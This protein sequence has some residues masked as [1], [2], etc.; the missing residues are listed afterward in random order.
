MRLSD[1]ICVLLSKCLLKAMLLSFESK[2]PLLVTFYN[3]TWSFDPF[4]P[5]FDTKCYEWLCNVFLWWNDLKCYMKWRKM[6]EMMWSL[7]NVVKYVKWCGMREMQFTNFGYMQRN[8]TL[9]LDLD[10]NLIILFLISLRIWA[11]VLMWNWLNRMSKIR[12]YSRGGL[13]ASRGACG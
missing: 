9:I 1:E 11:S 13:A 4:L 8:V 12:V 6:C 5:L 3:K 2:C 7:W 10:H